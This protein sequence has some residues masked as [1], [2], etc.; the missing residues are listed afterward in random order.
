MAA[1]CEHMGNSEKGRRHATQRSCSMAWRM[2]KRVRQALRG[3]ASQ[4]PLNAQ[5]LFVR[6]S[7]HSTS[8]QRQRRQ[9][10]Q[11]QRRRQQRQRT[12]RPTSTIPAQMN[13]TTRRTRNTRRK[14]RRH[15]ARHSAA[16]AAASASPSDAAVVARPR[17]EKRRS[18][19]A[20]V[21]SHVS[22]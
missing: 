1:N 10:Q 19:A 2:R 16:A 3:K 15:S 9:Q 4:E 21:G 13:I 11:L 8:Q 14:S 12:P 6:C 5:L 20:S 7:K 18:S 17:R 22:H